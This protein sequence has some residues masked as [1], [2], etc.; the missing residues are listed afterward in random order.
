MDKID[1][2]KLRRKPPEGDVTR[3]EKQTDFIIKVEDETIPV[4][5]DFLCTVSEYFR[6]MVDSELTDTKDGILTLKTTKPH[7]I[8][9]MIKYL[10][11]EEISIPWDDVRT[12]WILLNSGKFLG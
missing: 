9:T 3:K 10:Y 5:K 11:G 4:H 1:P 8:Q 2:L 12:M 7:V 6:A